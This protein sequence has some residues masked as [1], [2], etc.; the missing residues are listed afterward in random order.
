MDK[1]NAS[2]VFDKVDTFKFATPSLRF[3]AN[4][5]SIMLQF[6]CKIANVDK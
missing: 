6:D 1:Y 5:V 4:E 2:G 3:D